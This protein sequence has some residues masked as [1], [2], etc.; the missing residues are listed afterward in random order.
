MRFSL[1][2]DNLAHIF[3]FNQR[4]RHYLIQSQCHKVTRVETEQAFTD[5]W[6][7]LSGR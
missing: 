6:L 5:E 3:N 2:R 7:E 1:D 4:L